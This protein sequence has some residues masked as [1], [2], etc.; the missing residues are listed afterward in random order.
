[1]PIILKMSAATNLTLQ[2]LRKQFANSR[3]LFFQTKWCSNSVP[4]SYNVN[5]PGQKQDRFGS[6]GVSHDARCLS[7]R[8]AMDSR[9]NIQSGFDKRMMLVRSFSTSCVKSADSESGD[10]NLALSKKEQLQR[11]VKDYG[12][13]V[14]VFHVTISLASLGLF[15]LIVSRYVKRTRQQPFSYSFFLQWNRRREFGSKVAL[16]WGAPDLNVHGCRSQ[17]VRHRLRRPQSI[18]SRKNKHDLGGHSFHRSLFEIPR[19]LESKKA[20]NK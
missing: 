2:L 8:I 16:H 12:S 3:V 9:T 11:A 19:H 7:E 14:I 17:H 13:T 18:C 15:Y 4:T 1:M 6:D 20:L 5:L 10:P